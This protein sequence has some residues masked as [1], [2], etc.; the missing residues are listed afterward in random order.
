MLN[1]A[2]LVEGGTAALREKPSSKN[3][4]SELY[5]RKHPSA[6]RCLQCAS[7]DC[8]AGRK[9]EVVKDRTEYNI[10]ESNIVAN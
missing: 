7:G 1:L 10:R 5:E 9:F 2:A 4:P 6:E 8:Y 3:E